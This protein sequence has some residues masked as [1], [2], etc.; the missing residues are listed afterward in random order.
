MLFEQ[1]G[2]SLR[3]AAMGS[4]GSERKQLDHWTNA[5]VSSLDR[6][7]R[8]ATT[9]LDTE[10][11][12][13]IGL[14]GVDQNCFL[15]FNASLMMMSVNWSLRIIFFQLASFLFILIKGHCLQ[16]AVRICRF[17]VNRVDSARNRTLFS[18]PFAPP[19]ILGLK[20]PLSAYII[21]FAVL[22]CEH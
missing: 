21:L 1:R 20:G 7:K 2:K 9:E 15:P 16:C 8:E 19:I 10:P 4:N 6:R 17:H 5:I 14:H 3:I 12:K 18:P 22:R 11:Q 13:V